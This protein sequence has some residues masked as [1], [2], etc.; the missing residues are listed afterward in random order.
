MKSKLGIVTFSTPSEQLQENEK[1]RWV[2]PS[3]A[4]YRDLPQAMAA[5]LLPPILTGADG[6]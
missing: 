3:G 5:N 4:C 1:C 2:T 6:F